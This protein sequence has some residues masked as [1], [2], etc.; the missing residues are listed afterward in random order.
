VLK[1]TYPSDALSAT[2]CHKNGICDRVDGPAQRRYRKWY[3]AVNTWP[4]DLVAVENFQCILH[5]AI[6][7]GKEGL[8]Q[9]CEIRCQRERLHS[10][11][12]WALDRDSNDKLFRNRRFRLLHKCHHLSSTILQIPTIF[13]NRPL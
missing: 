10:R 6:S 3:A 11:A 8:A 13:D 5:E 9:Y 1:R 7:T 2:S 12:R 4:I